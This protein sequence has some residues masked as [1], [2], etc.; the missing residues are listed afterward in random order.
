M[1][2]TNTSKLAELE[3][4]L[5]GMGRVGV[6]FSGGV[7]STFLA[8]VCARCAAG[9]SVLIHIDTPLA[10]TPER[11]AIACVRTQLELPFV[12]IPFDPLIHDAVAANPPNRCYHC[13]RVMFGQVMRVAAWL[14]CTTVLEGSNADDLHDLRPGMR[15]VREL[16]ARSPLAEFNWTKDEERELLRAWGFDTWNMPAQACLATRVATGECITPEKLNVI[17]ACED[18]LHA[19]GLTQVRVRLNDGVA[20]VYAVPD[21]LSL[22]TPALIAAIKSKGA[23]VIAHV[24]PQVR[25]YR[26]GQSG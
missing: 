8:A 19:Q 22:I 25:E 18:L 2:M 5:R 17:R 10:T 24:D 20:H 11:E 6:A 23:G 26:S 9:R 16:G 21:E 3:S 1:N 13:K 4:T 14:G 15:A 12:S 7:D